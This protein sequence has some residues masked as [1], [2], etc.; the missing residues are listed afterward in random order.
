MSRNIYLKDIREKRYNVDIVL[1]AEKK[2]LIERWAL[3]VKVKRT[4][5]VC[6]L[7]NFDSSISSNVLL[8]FII[9]KILEIC[10]FFFLCL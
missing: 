3:Y 7:Y 6:Q 9:Y 10:F 4:S 1:I 2:N 5:R 8:E